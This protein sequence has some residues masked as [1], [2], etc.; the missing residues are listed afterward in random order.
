MFSSRWTCILLAVAAPMAA[1]AQHASN[2]PGSAYPSRVIRIVV[3]LT[4]GGPTDILA[5]II[6]QPLAKRLG[7]AVVFD[8]KPGAGGN[9][10]ADAVAKSPP[11][12]YTLFLV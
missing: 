2:E 12:G 6:A 4:A 3:P 9:I 11:D 7:Q 1:L 10:G 8:N 5:R